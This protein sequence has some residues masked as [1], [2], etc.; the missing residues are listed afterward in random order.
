MA[1]LTAIKQQIGM[2]SLVV[3]PPHVK[4][5]HDA[6]VDDPGGKKGKASYDAF[7]SNRS[8]VAY[9]ENTGVEDF[10]EDEMRAIGGYVAPRQSGNLPANDDAAREQ[11]L[12]AQFEKRQA[13]ADSVYEKYHSDEGIEQT[14]KK[15][16]QAVEQDP[17]IKS[18]RQK[19]DII[20]KINDNA[21]KEKTKVFAAE[22]QQYGHMAMQV[23]QIADNIAQVQLNNLDRQKQAETDAVEHSHMSATAKQKALDKINADTLAKERA[24]KKEQ[25]EWSIAQALINGALAIMNI[26]AAPGQTWPIGLIETVLMAATT[27]SEIAVISS[28]KFA[29]GGVVQGT[30]GTDSQHVMATPG[31][32]VLTGDQQKNLY[33]I[34]RGNG[35]T[36]TNNSAQ[37]NYDMS[38]VVQGNASQATVQAIRQTQVQQV[39]D[40]KRTMA[41]AQRMRQAA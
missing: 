36:T 7:I 18:A 9:P 15:Q 37:H 5:P 1:E 13:A 23:T 6:G 40:L 39:R 34:A 3:T 20:K 22:A 17:E 26:W 29:Q 30:G 10:R 19:A 25:Q 24:A 16:L 14:R 31:E 8:P 21:L 2:N 4:T 33:D 38:I 27:A 41:A 12:K 28:Q 11:S 35:S 32:M